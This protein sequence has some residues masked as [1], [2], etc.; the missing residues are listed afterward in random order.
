MLADHSFSH[1]LT[2]MTF[3]YL[4][5]YYT[6][7][8]PKGLQGV[9]K[10]KNLGPKVLK[11]KY[12]A[13]DVIKVMFRDRINAKAQLIFKEQK[14]KKLMQASRPALQEV[15]K[16][17]TPEEARKVAKVLKEWNSGKIATESSRRL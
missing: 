16:A 4:A 11:K 12:K 1:L 10:V 15:D 13:A 17:L 8:E 7:R 2:G 3:Q 6:Q 9:P 14:F 5:S